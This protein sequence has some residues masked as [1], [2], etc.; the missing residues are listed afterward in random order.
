MEK[1]NFKRTKLSCYFAY[2]AMASVAGL[3]PMLFV[4]FNDMYHVSYTLLGTLV[5]I[6]FCTQLVVD[7]IFS[8]FTKYFNVKTTVRL[9]P[10]LTTLGLIIYALS[11]VIFSTH[12]YMG[13]V[14][15][16]L[17]FSTAAGLCE[18][19]ISPIVAALPSDTPA[20]DMS[21]LHSLYGW[22]VVTVVIINTLYFNIFGRENWMYLALLWAILPLI[23]SYLFCISPIPNMDA[24]AHRNTGKT[25]NK[26]KGL[27]LFTL[28]IFFGSAAENSMTNWISTFMEDTLHISKSIGD[29]FGMAAFA[30]LLAMTRNAYAKYGKNIWKVLFWGMVGATGCY[31]IVGLS[32]NVTISFLACIF[33]GVCTAMLWPGTL[34]L[35][36]ERMPCLGVSAYALM[37]AGGDLGASAAPQILGIVAD[38]W[39]IKTGMLV[40]ALFPLLGI[41]IILMIKN[42]KSGADTVK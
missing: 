19:L 9:M 29:V 13:F 28:C 17:A 38:N 35:M 24:A 1:E 32:S 41:L 12:I 16:T 15:G 2:V 5:L 39:G 11:P 20:K 18:V 36:E 33:T 31:I 4:T 37:A 42:Q 3:P 8:F 23:S 34:I 27:I 7:L 6:N 26:A 25:G 21:T 30:V 22:G 14:L 40:T 10:I